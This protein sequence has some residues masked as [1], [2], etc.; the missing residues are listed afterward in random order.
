MEVFRK[1]ALVTGSS[2]GI[3]RSTAIELMSA[4]Y[5]VIGISRNIDLNDKELID[6]AGKHD[7]SYDCLRADVSIHDDQ[8]RISDFVKEKSDYLNVLVHNAGVAPLERKDVLEMSRESFDRVMGINLGAPVFLTQLLYP[9]LS[10]ASSAQLIFVSSISAVT[11]SVNRAEYC[12]SKAALSMFSQ[13]MA[14]RLAQSSIRVYEVRPGIIE[15]DMTKPVLDDY[16]TQ[17]AN[18]LVPQNRMGQPKDI[19]AVIR[20]LVS[21]DFDYANGLVLEVSGG[22]Q[23][24]S[25]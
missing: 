9:L 23:V 1:Y 17:I 14:D 22:M 6:L 25:L 8:L 4:G 7:V 10:K 20:S 15:T 16:K 21:G 2:R 19:A 12:M 24:R 11:A 18:G 13:V 5:C 3:G